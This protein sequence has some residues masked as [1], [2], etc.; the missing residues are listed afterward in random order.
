MPN[1]TYDR[2]LAKS[3]AGEIVFRIW[4]ESGDSPLIPHRYP[5]RSGFFAKH[6]FARQMDEDDYRDTCGDL[7]LEVKDKDTWVR[8]SVLEHVRGPGDWLFN[9]RA[10]RDAPPHL[11]KPAR[12]LRCARTGGNNQDLL[13][14]FGDDN[15]EKK[16]DTTSSPWIVTHG[17]L[18]WVIHRIIKLLSR[19]YGARYHMTV[20]HIGEDTV[21]R[22]TQSA[23][24]LKLLK[25]HAKWGQAERKLVNEAY[26]FAKRSEEVLFYGRIFGG[27][28]KEDFLW[29]NDVS[30]EMR[31]EARTC[32]S[33][34]S[35]ASSVQLAELVLER[36]CPN[37]PSILDGQPHLGTVPNPL[38]FGRDM[39]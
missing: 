18:D 34:P 23:D 24:H 10:I 3:Q 6:T 9:K 36:E 31:R 16:E 2:L 1:T 5:S 35:V 27:S 19:D 38:H 32:T 22:R 20:I 17:K 14:D 37:P 28:V 33:S 26:N 30:F 13:L 12:P 25:Q 7:S 15:E 29:S 11:A 39:A 4:C 8:Y 21:E